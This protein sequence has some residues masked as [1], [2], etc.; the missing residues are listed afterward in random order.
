MK[1]KDIHLSQVRAVLKHNKNCKSVQEAIDFCSDPKN[2]SDIVHYA[3]LFKDI[4]GID[5]RFHD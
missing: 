3:N 5:D 4:Q 2:K 1:E